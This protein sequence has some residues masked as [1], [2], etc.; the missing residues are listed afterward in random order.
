M[1]RTVIFGFHKKV[2]HASDFTYLG[3]LNVARSD[4]G[5][6]SACFPSQFWSNIGWERQ[7]PQGWNFCNFSEDRMMCNFLKVQWLTLDGKRQ[8][9]GINS[10]W[11][12]IAKVKIEQKLKN[13]EVLTRRPSYTAV[14]PPV[15]CHG[16]NVKLKNKKVSPLETL[17]FFAATCYWYSRLILTKEDGIRSNEQ[18]SSWV[19]S[20]SSDSAIKSAIQF[21]TL[22]WHRSSHGIL[23]ELPGVFPFQFLEQLYCGCKE[24]LCRAKFISKKKS[25]PNRILCVVLNNKNWNYALSK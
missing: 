3:F 18:T 15:S 12:V 20:D 16:I 13:E 8:K 24:S 5:E 14:W 17:T 4:N 23:I 11:S 19:G 22:N 7:N 2:R 10:N 1:T 6:L 9:K 25:R 21:E